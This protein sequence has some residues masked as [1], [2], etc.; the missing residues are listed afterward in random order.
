MPGI[1]T[2][3]TTSALGHPE[4][5]KSQQAPIPGGLKHKDSAQFG[6]KK[7]QDKLQRL[8]SAPGTNLTLFQ[9]SSRL[10][11]EG[12]QLHLHSP[13]LKSRKSYNFEMDLYIAVLKHSYHAGPVSH[14]G[15]GLI[16]FLGKDW[17]SEVPDPHLSST[18][19]HTVSSPAS[20]I[21]VGTGGWV[22]CWT[23]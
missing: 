21:L 8:N 7:L 13:V 20:S 2:S 4:A 10:A 17:S 16:A 12:T 23:R 1:T 3:E 6:R 5:K 19:A 11:F 14:S 9:Q 22:G 18:H 15:T